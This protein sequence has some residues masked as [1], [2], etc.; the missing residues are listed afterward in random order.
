L[1]DL[2]RDLEN[3]VR[4]LLKSLGLMIGKSSVSVLPNRIVALL[5]D[6]PHLR[7]LINPLMTA[8]STLAEQIAFYDF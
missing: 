7:S 6:A 3:Q 8:H 5:R 4:G 2:R 1:V